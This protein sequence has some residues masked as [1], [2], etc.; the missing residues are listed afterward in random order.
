MMTAA[1]ADGRH[2]ARR[3]MLRP[4]C[5]LFLT[6]STLRY[7]TFSRSLACAQGHLNLS[8]WAGEE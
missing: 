8:P 1:A 2:V 7:M 4:S 3:K 5:S 6:L